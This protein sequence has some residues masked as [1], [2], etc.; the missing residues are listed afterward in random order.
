M[1]QPTL[2]SF[3]TALHRLAER[4]GAVEIC[5]AG[6]K[7]S[8]PSMSFR[9]RVMAVQPDGGLVLEAPAGPGAA[10]FV[11]GRAA[12]EVLVASGDQRVVGRAMVTGAGRRDLG[13]GTSV[14][15]MHLGRPE[16]VRS[17]Q[18]RHFFRV[19]AVGVSDAPVLLRPLA[20]EGAT[21]CP[22]PLSGVLCNLGGGGLGV[23]VVRTRQTLETLRQVR[24][25]MAVVPLPDE[26]EPL[27]VQVRLVHLQALPDDLL[28]LG[29]AFEFEDAAER[30]QVEMRV[31]RATTQIERRQL[32][33]RRRA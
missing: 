9:V 5:A 18:R 2:D 3:V 31:V 27:E 30:R 28:Y 14:R 22:V 21:H 16:A 19:S 25:V 24:G 23:T 4:N 32:Q 12:V 20:A 8:G 7:G 1:V 6:A 15:T 17:G 10:A 11:R 26:A 13:G 29:M 33:R